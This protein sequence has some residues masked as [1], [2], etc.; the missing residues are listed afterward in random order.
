MNEII[1]P[2]MA[3]YPSAS[4]EDIANAII[5]FIETSFPEILR[6]MDLPRKRIPAPTQVAIRTLRKRRARRKFARVSYMASDSRENLISELYR[7]R[8]EFD[9]AAASGTVAERTFESS[10]GIGSDGFEGEI[11]EDAPGKRS[12]ISQG[13]GVT[14]K[15]GIIEPPGSF[16]VYT[17]RFSRLEPPRIRFSLGPEIDEILEHDAMFQDILRRT[18][19]NLRA[20]ALQSKTE[21]DFHVGLETDP[22][23]PK[24]KRFV[25]T[26]S[27]SADF[28]TKMA[29]W[30]K[31]NKSV[32][33]AL[34]ELEEIH[35]EFSSKIKE[36]GKNLFVHMELA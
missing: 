31:L 10:G 29:L 17:N 24:W 11:V 32:R 33:I 19:V 4:V 27:P 14:S 16:Q 22:E 8:S 12:L 3:S 21:M 9:G 35:P 25:V 20:A 34:H 28:E 36:I 1:D 7:L 2:L 26:V 5:A 6:T 23:Y 15:L 30:P 18:E 13:D